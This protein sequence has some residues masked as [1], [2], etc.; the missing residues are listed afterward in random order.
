MIH[1]NNFNVVVACQDIGGCQ[2]LTPVMLR[3]CQDGTEVSLYTVSARA[4]YFKMNSLN[5][6]VLSGELLNQIDEIL[7]SR[8]PQ[9]VLLG[10][11][12]GHSIEDDFVAACRRREIPTVAFLDSWNLYSERFSDPE[13]G[14]F[15][16]YCPDR[17]CVTD[18]WARDEMLEEGFLKDKR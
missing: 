5:A 15:F 7:E 18:T 17:I 2:A 4:A 1:E 16:K 8:R 13:T 10:T 9:A 12:L 3:L 11:S 14:E 6:H